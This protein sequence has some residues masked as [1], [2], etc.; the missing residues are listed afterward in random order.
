VRGPVT[1]VDRW[2][3][4]SQ[5]TFR[6]SVIVPTVND[7]TLFKT[8]EAI[9]KQTRP[10]NEILVVG[11][12]EAGAAKGIPAVRFV[13]TETRVC[14]AA[15]RNKGIQLSSGNLLVFTDSDC[16]PDPHWLKRHEHA[17][18]NGYDIVGGGV[19]FIGSNFWAQA[20]NV[21]MFHDFMTALE[22]GNRQLLPTL[23]LSVQRH[24]ID[25]VGLMDESF[26]GAAAEDSDWTVRMRL[27]GYR[28]YFEP[29]ASIC[30]APARIRRSDV[31]RHWRNLGYSSIR[32]RHRF[33]EYFGTP[34]FARNP[35]L[36]RLLSPIVAVKVTTGIYAKPS[37]WPYL[38]YLPVVYATKIIYCLGAAAS[39]EEGFAFSQE[40]TYPDPLS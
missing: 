27:A 11:R 34:G 13:D 7:D 24:V 31:V 4:K 28:L 23:N 25:S 37:L 3:R 10:P 14:A 9:L 18:E 21:S 30:H 39:I 1:C 8:L 2:R 26:P 33:A 12:D 22:Q 19:S 6:I 38:H 15:A 29:R 35:M 17:H 32:V 20:D 16:I 5:V 36:L 40:R